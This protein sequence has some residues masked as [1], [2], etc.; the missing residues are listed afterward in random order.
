[1]EQVDSDTISEEEDRFE[2]DEVEEWTM[3]TSN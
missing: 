3:D 1:M 2:V